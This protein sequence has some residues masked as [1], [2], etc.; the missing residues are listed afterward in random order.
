MADEPTAAAPA[1]QV[2]SPLSSPSP[3]PAASATQAPAAA[4]DQ[5]P[6]SPAG[7]ETNPNPAPAETPAT[8]A[9]PDGIPDTYW[10]TTAN[11]LKVDPAVLA[12]DL[13][14]RD[15]LKAF[16]A[17]DDVRKQS[18]PQSPDAYKAELPPDFKLPVGV[19]FK[20]DENAPELK[21]ARAM[22]HAKGWSQTD[23]SDA[24]AIFAAGKAGEQ[25]QIDAARTRE[26]EKL[27]PTAPARVDAVTRFLS[28][29]DT[30]ADK[31]D[32]KALAGMLVTA[33]H[34]EAFERLITRFTSQGV[35]PFSQKHREGPDAGK[36]ITGW[37]KMS[38]EQRRAAQDNARRAQSR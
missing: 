29:V 3:A 31:G 14:E 19:E 7:T 30:S 4:S 8:V 13:R 32:A 28:G 6:A 17:A 9:R 20:F 26:I 12:N 35:A 33:R 36:E 24:L 11:T 16:K 25:A 21:Q 18:L 37:D 2:T 5:T 23:F 1:A 34:V 27:G 22:A 15:E 38:F 10:D